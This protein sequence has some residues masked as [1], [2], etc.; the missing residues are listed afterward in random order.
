ML[1]HGHR[2]PSLRPV[3][4]PRPE[5][6]G[7]PQGPGLGSLGR[8]TRHEMFDAQRRSDRSLRPLWASNVSV[9]FASRAIATDGVFGRLL[10]GPRK[11]GSCHRH[12]SRSQHTGHEGER[13]RVLSVRWCFYSFRG[14]CALA[15]SAGRACCSSFGR[16]RSCIAD[17]RSVVSSRRPKRRIAVTTRPSHTLPRTWPSH[18]CCN[19]GVPCAVPVRKDV[20][21]RKDLSLGR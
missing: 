3:R 2:L 6:R 11:G 12:H 4:C 7:R 20:A 8:F 14:L 17:I 18:H 16:S 13:I 5:G 9:V 10:R 15:T 21:V 19:R 1:P